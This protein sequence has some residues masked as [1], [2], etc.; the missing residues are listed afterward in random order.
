MTPVAG[1]E[2]GLGG[3]Q[4]PQRSVLVH[5]YTDPLLKVSVQTV[6]KKQLLTNTR[7]ALLE[8]LTSNKNNSSYASPDTR[9]KTGDGSEALLASTY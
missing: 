9:P 7:N 3:P 1:P 6:K 5:T 2:W 8:A 4:G